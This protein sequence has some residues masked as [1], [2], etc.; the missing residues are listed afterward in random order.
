MHNPDL[1]REIEKADL[2]ITEISE[3]IKSSF[4]AVRTVNEAQLKEALE[5]RE[6][7]RKHLE[8]DA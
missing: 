5:K 2:L 8:S 6:A 7:L 3:A 4:N 1:Q